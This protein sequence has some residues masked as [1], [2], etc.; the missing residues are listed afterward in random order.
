MKLS[1]V[2]PGNIILVERMFIDHYGVYAGQGQVIHYAPRTEGGEPVIHKAGIDRF[3][4][5]ASGFF[6]PYMPEN[7]DDLKMLINHHKKRSDISQEIVDELFNQ[8]QTGKMQIYTAEQTLNRAMKRIGEKDY[9]LFSNNCEHFAFWCKFG[10]CIS[11]QVSC[12][13]EFF[14]TALLRLGTQRYHRFVNC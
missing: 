2:K 1:E 8:Y 6:V 4:D 10:V 12:V 5:G 11:N 3:L 14:K 9:S 13:G 7:Q